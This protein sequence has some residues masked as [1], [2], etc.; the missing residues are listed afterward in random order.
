MDIRDKSW[1]KIWD[2]RSNDLYL[3]DI[4]KFH[5][6]GSDNTLLV[7]RTNNDNTQTLTTQKAA[8]PLTQE[9]EVK[10]AFRALHIARR[11]VAPADLSTEILM[12]FLDENNFLYNHMSNKFGKDDCLKPF[13][14]QVLCSF[15]DSIISENGDRVDQNS[16]P[17][18]YKE[19]ED[20]VQ[21]FLLSKH[22]H[23]IPRNEKRRFSQNEGSTGSAP[24]ASRSSGYDTPQNR[25]PNYNPRAP[26][27]KKFQSTKESIDHYDKYICKLYNE[28]GKARD[29]SKCF[30][31]KIP[32][33]CTKNGEEF[34]HTCRWKY[35][36]PGEDGTFCHLKHPYFEHK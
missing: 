11:F 26:K 36:K 31:Q 33:G 9:K 3:K 2:L 17:L 20:R 35:D 12:Q 4:L 25:H 21:P 22:V 1:L 13:K 7:E 6:K 14:A 16:A 15:I 5:H 19:I 29:G 18:T 8:P 10:S 27:G 23:Y 30:N 34:Y 24:K 32:T 28:S